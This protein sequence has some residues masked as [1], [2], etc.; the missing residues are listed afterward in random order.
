MIQVKLSPMNIAIIGAGPAGLAAAHDFL[1]AGHSATI[2]E[3]A[4]AP[5]GLAAGFKEPH[6]K[7]SVEKFY[8]H[9]FQSDADLLKL[10]DETGLRAGVQFHSPKTV[11]YWNGNFYPLDSPVAALLFPG[12]SLF[13]KIPFGLATIYLKY[14]TGNGIGLEKYT[15]HDWASRWMGKGAYELIFQPLLD[16]KFG[17]AYSRKVNMAW[18]WARLKSRTSKL[19]TYEGGGQKF[20]DDLAANLQKRGANIV[21]S[22][23]VQNLAQADGAW[24]VAVSI[25]QQ[26]AQ[27]QKF[28]MVLSTTS[29]KVM[30]KLAPQL[31]SNYLGALNDLKSLGAVVAVFSLSHPLSENGYYWHS[32]P[33]S[34]GFPYLAMCEHT[35]FVSPENFGGDRIVYCGDYLPA[36]HR[37]FSMSADEIAAEYAPSLKRFNEKFDPSWIKKTW[38][39][40]EAYAQPVP[41]VNHSRNVPPTK[42]P[43]PGL[44]FA[45]MS[46]VYPWDRGTNF[47]VEIGRRVAREMMAE[48]K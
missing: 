41:L 36:D 19:G 34:A 26:A 29:P 23:R 35:N 38:V 46:Q 30:G 3:A 25:N 14:L 15:A 17:E 40:K 8:H 24:A 33:K 5:G 13:D 2:F 39:F 22:A 4:S 45:S 9:W 10:A 1:N 7:W 16:G 31:P 28:D 6:W 48:R 43:L 42:T 32:L 27:T 47:A 21:Y 20:Y 12:L 11:S 18:L 37:Y 44:Y